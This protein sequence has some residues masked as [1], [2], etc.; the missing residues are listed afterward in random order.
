MRGAAGARGDRR[1]RAG[2]RRL[3][4]RDDRELRLHERR[5]QALLRHDLPRGRRRAL[6]TT[7][8]R[9]AGGGRQEAVTACG[10]TAATTRPARSARCSRSSAPCRGRQA[11]EVLEVLGDVGEDERAAAYELGGTLAAL[12]GGL[13]RR[14]YDHPAVRSRVRADEEGPCRTSAR[15]SLPSCSASSLL[16]ALGGCTGESA[17]GSNADPD[18][19][20]AVEAPE[21]G[22]CRVLTPDGRGPAQQRDPHRRLLASRTPRRPTRS[23][24]CPTPFEDA[25]YDDDGRSGP[26]PTRP[27]RRSS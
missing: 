25:D 26:G 27:A 3:P 12:L 24:S 17:R 10:C 20:D 1:R 2:R 21:L 5:A 14:R 23:A 6:P 22:A 19:V 16:L 13:S 11:A 15:S 9:A 7:G 8:R 4:A 18:Q